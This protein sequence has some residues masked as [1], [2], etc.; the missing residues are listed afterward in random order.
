MKLTDYKA[1]AARKVL[2][3]GQPK[4]GKTELTGKLSH[5]KKLWY[6]DLEDG[7]KSLLKPGIA[8]LD[9]IEYFKIPDTQLYPIAAETLIKV[10][11]GGQV[12]ICHT[13]GKIGC[14]VCKSADQL[15]PINTSTFT[16]QDVLVIDSVSQLSQSIMNYILKDRLAKSDDVKPEW[17]DWARQ[18]LILDRIFSNL[19]QAPFNVIA[20]TH[21]NL[22]EM[23]DGK[24]KLVPVAGSSQ[25][26]KTF[27]KYFDD[28]AY[29]ETSNRKFKSYT[30]VEDCIAPAIVGSRAGIK[31]GDAGLADLFK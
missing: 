10:V 30:S 11:R 22:V 17:N 13:H 15:S 28:V 7:I 24:K 19:Q 12:S 3:Y 1:N 26:G 27:A 14:A 8:N 4:S 31:I 29:L 23:E 16:N 25:F 18:G 20:I 5:T 9:N 6:F 21:E 2:V